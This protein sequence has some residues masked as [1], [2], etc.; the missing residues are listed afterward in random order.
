MAELSSNHIQGTLGERR[1]ADAV[2]ILVGALVITLGLLPIMELFF[3]SFTDKAIGSDGLFIGFQNYSKIFASH[4]YYT[5]LQQTL[6][7]AVFSV[8]IKLVSGLALA[9]LVATVLS[10]TRRAIGWIAPILLIPW[11]IPTVA[12]ML[13]W[14]WILYDLGGLLNS[15]L[16]T[17]G[18]I[19]SNIA[20]LGDYKLATT[21][22]IVVN[23]WRGTGFFFAS[24]LASRLSI[25]NQRYWIGWI[26]R[27]SYTRIFRS[28]TLPAI[29][30]TLT[31]VTLISI[32]N[33]YTD[34]QI[35]HLLTDGGP[36]DST[37]IFSTMIYEYAFRG[38]STLGYASAFAVALSPPLILTIIILIRFLA[39]RNLRGFE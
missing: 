28:I 19:S 11:A 8:S 7:Y 18:L 20:W 1:V 24:I 35:V 32:I 3:W 14:S 30:P 34:F 4:E 27:A 26:E 12:S 37:Q 23:V 21:S 33:T 38:R 36:G 22:L 10:S 25:P 31:I 9:L 39:T 15:V 13:I 2:L 29:L 17:S 5:V 16:R 6:V